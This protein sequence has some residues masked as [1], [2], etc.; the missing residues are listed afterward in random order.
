[1]YK[2]AY[3]LLTDIQGLSVLF[4]SIKCFQVIREN[5]KKRVVIISFTNHLPRHQKCWYA[6]WAL[7]SYLVN[8]K[9]NKLLYHLSKNVAPAH[10][11]SRTFFCF[12]LKCKKTV[13]SDWLL[14]SDQMLQ[15]FQHCQQ[16]LSVIRVRT[17]AV[18][19]KAHLP[20]VY[21]QQMTFQLYQE[22]KQT[23]E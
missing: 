2:L 20:L 14:K 22:V 5:P 12:F 18:N 17:A 10:M 3:Q 4:L 1:M 15:M 21:S 11:W 7:F 13:H 9:Y 23:A 6:V 19:M 8:K 16:S